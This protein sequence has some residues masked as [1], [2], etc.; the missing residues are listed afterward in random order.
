MVSVHILNSLCTWK[1]RLWLSCI[2]LKQLKNIKQSD[3]QWL[4]F[5]NKI[6]TTVASTVPNFTIASFSLCSVLIWAKS[7]A[8][9]GISARSRSNSLYER[10]ALDRG[11]G[12]SYGRDH[13]HL[14]SPVNAL[15]L[16]TQ[17]FCAATLKS[18]RNSLFTRGRNTKG[19]HTT[20][21][22]IHHDQ[23]WIMTHTSS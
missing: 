20:T 12:N 1:L 13:V 22:A 6:P 4:M 21:S 3:K 18:D 8:Y 9:M 11:H 14:I 10:T 23:S 17:Q 19:G 7:H 16:G 15:P 2:R 5:S